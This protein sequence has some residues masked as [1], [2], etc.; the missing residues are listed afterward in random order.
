MSAK[1]PSQAFQARCSVQHIPPD[2]P[3]FLTNSGFL[4]VELDIT[5]VPTG[6]YVLTLNPELDLSKNQV[7]G[8]YV[9][10]DP[11]SIN[12]GFMLSGTFNPELLPNKIQMA[13]MQL[14]PSESDPVN[15]PFQVQIV[16]LE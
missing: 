9:S 1:N 13:R 14:V 2:P 7:T 3:F 10:H 11:D 8:T 5:A 6:A 15:G 16:N 4:S 12:M